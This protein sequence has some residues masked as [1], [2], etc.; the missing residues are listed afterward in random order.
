M[1]DA[2]YQ[3]GIRDFDLE[4]AYEA[5]LKNEMDGKNRPQGAGKDD[6]ADFVELGYAPHK[7]LPPQTPRLL[8]RCDR[9]NS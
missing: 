3:C 9:L 2:A 5:C 1:I 4:L 7:E 6:T 8:Q